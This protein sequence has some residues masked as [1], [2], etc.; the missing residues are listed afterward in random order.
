[1]GIVGGIAQMGTSIA[2][3]VQGKEN[4]D[5]N[6]ELQKDQFEYQKMNQQT[7]YDRADNAVSRRSQDMEN[8]GFSKTLATGAPAQAGAVVS[9][10]APQKS[11]GNQMMGLSSIGK[12]SQQAQV[13]QGLM[14]Q[15]AQ[16]GQ[17]KA[18]TA[19]INSQK[20]SVNTNNTVAQHTGMTVGHN[21]TWQTT[22][23]SIV[24]GARTEIAGYGNRSKYKILHNK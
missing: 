18:Q 19:L 6:F 8:A 14:Q 23:G 16:I 3:L 17:I 2:Q 21:P 12:A 4:S 10:V 13:I 20:A 5:R 22:L 15:K 24:A 1:M 9:T 11:V 7:Q